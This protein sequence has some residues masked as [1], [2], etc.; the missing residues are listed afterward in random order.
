M[1]EVGR[2]GVSES[3]TDSSV[4][5]PLSNVAFFYLPVNPAL[6][7]HVDSSK[8]RSAL[9]YSLGKFVDVHGH[10][11]LVLVSHDMCNKTFSLLTEI[12]TRYLA[13][14]LQVIPVQSAAAAAAAMVDIA[15]LQCR[16]VAGKMQERF[17]LLLNRLLLED[18]CP[19]LLHQLGLDT[20]Q[21]QLV[22][23][24][25]GSLS[26]LTSAST[27]DLMD[28]ALDA[29]TAVAVTRFFHHTHA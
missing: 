18:V 12:Q 27:A 25:I 11:Y 23:D 26:R 24:G 6:F 22:Q 13:S 4:I 20:H 15:K 8:Q 2:M 14:R 10:S 9:F 17:C 19:R 3:S 21:L 5:F 28:C 29:N 1:G 7:S 16:P